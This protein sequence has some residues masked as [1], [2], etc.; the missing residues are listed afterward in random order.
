M[1]HTS[2]ALGARRW[3]VAPAV[4]R[5]GEGKAPPGALPFES[6]RLR[7]NKKKWTP[8]GESIFLCS[9]GDGVRLPYVHQP[10]GKSPGMPPP[11]ENGD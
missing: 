1:T 5:F 6:H 3:R 10:L 4:G 9:G 7:P 11:Y 8:A 2:R